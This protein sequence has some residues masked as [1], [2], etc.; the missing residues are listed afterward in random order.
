MDKGLGQPGGGPSE[1]LISPGPCQERGTGTERVE[2][3]WGA[4]AWPVWGGRGWAVGWE[5]Q[6]PL[7]P[8]GKGAG[9]SPGDQKPLHLR[10]D[11]CRLHRYST[12]FTSFFHSTPF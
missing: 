2:V 6:R 4:S 12:H 9:S 1:G 5:W 8:H 7:G 11:A 10:N 3:G